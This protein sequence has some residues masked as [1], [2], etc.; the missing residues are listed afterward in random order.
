MMMRM[1]HHMRRD[2]IPDTRDAV[3]V[4]NRDTLAPLVNRSAR[5]GK[6]RWLFRTCAQAA[7]VACGVLAQTTDA[8]IEFSFVTG[9]DRAESESSL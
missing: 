7:A 3:E 5:A 4:P 8:E 9:A 1:L 6:T 2:Q